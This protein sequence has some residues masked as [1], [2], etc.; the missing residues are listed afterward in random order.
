MGQYDDIINLDRPMS[1]RPKMALRDRAKI[2]MPFAALKGHDEAI[3]HQNIQLTERV[4]LSEELKEELDKKIKVLEDMEEVSDNITFIITYYKVYED[5]SREEGREL[6]KYIEKTGRKIK[7]DRVFQKII[8]DDVG[9]EFKDIQDIT[10]GE[11][12]NKI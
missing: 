1:S 5:V 2:F 10:W 12:D 9:I 6:G 7:I 8:L 11:L 4:D 3:E